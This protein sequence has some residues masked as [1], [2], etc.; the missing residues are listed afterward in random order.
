MVSS[1]VSTYFE[2]Y[3]GS[4][5]DLANLPIKVCGFRQTEASLTEGS[6]VI[7]SLSSKRLYHDADTLE[8]QSGS[9][10]YFM[11]GG[12]AKVV[13]IHTNGTTNTADHPNSGRKIDDELIAYYNNI[14]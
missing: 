5:E 6:G 3:N 7:T 12:K 8:G 9:P 2:L 10:I 11:S 13:G 14:K 1:Y 4:E